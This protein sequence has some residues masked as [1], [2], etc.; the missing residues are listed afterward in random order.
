[1]KFKLDIVTPE[2]L[3]WSDDVD[4]VTIPT[5]Q[6]EITILAHHVPIVTIIEPGELKIR[7]ESETIYMAVSGGFIQVT[8]KKVTIL[9]D[10]AERAEEIDINRAERAREQAKKLLSEKRAE[11]VPNA[12]AMAALQRSLTRLKVAGRRRKHDYR[13]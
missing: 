1:M 2:R 11:K 8:G 13:D 6:G 4:F 3:I 10:A 12:E 7:R 5:V 9:A